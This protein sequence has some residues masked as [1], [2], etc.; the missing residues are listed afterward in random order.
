[1]LFQMS[2]CRG[3]IEVV[4][5]FRTC[6]A[7]A[8]KDAFN[9]PQKSFVLAPGKDRRLGW[10]NCYL[11]MPPMMPAKKESRTLASRFNRERNS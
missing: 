3:K 6:A 2:I 8:K 7:N 5:A 4:I 10:L 9:L 11:A 1:M